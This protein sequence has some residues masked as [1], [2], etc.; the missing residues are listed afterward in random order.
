MIK[1]ILPTMPR[2]ILNDRFALKKCRTLHI[3]DQTSNK[4][5]RVS[6]F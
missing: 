6:S 3:E 2:K 1:K 4:K 5:F